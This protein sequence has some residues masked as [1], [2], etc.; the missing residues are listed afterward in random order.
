MK[1]KITPKQYRML[2]EQ[3]ADSDVRNFFSAEKGKVHLLSPI[4]TARITAAEAIKRILKSEN[5]R[6]SFG[7][8]I[9]LN[10]LSLVNRIRFGIYLNEIMKEK[11]QVRGL[12]FEGFMAGLLDG[13]LP[14][15]TNY[16][17]DYRILDGTIEQKFRESPTDNPQLKTFARFYETYPEY[18]GLLELPNTTEEI[19][20]R[21]LEMLNK[22][23]FLPDYFIFSYV[24][25]LKIG[26]EISNRVLTKDEVI[27]I[28]MD[29]ENNKEPQSKGQTAIRLS[30]TKLGPVDFV[31]KTPR[32]TDK[33]LADFIKLNPKEQAV[34]SAFGKHSRHI[35]PDVIKDLTKNLDEFIESL[36]EIQEEYG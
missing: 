2:T 32:Y 13:I 1:F 19:I 21:K 30:H 18:K 28:V 17:F 7:D 9:D 29:P 23:N 22:P 27:K 3:S 24:T 33:E 26:Y 14:N 4:P 12:A 35:R 20:N 15:K 11:G 36:I 25:K 34:I 16:W 31:I 10:E 5:K 8:D 6:Y